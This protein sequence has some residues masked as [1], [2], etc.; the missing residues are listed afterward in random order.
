M[1]MQEFLGEKAI[2]VLTNEGLLKKASNGLG[3]LFPYCGLRKKALEV[4]I[5]EIENSDMST[6]E[7]VSRILSAK[8]TLKRL[9]NQSKIIDFAIENSEPN[10]DFSCNSSVKSEW[11][12]R[13]M[14]DAKFV[15]EEEIQFIWGKILSKEYEKPGSVPLNIGRILSE[16]TK[17]K[18][19]AFIN[20]CS[21]NVIM[22]LL[23][24]NS[25]C[26]ARRKDIIV[27]YTGNSKEMEKLGITFEMLNELETIGLIKFKDLFEYVTDSI[28]ARY[29]ILHINNKVEAYIEHKNETLP[30]GNV[31]LTKSGLCLCNL[32]E[33]RKIPH[34]NDMIIKY[35]Q[36]KGVT[37]IKK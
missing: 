36:D 10:T 29:I 12:E 5:N 16:L 21:M 27:P 2:E 24:D 35:Y 8:D 19:E 28:N 31:F 14:D 18:A 33:E 22:D 34:Y 37:F 30:K 15:D 32:L 9:K 25:N 11:I 3:L 20:I 4:Y 6:A 23:D 17:D 7:K 13:F 26:T 1:V